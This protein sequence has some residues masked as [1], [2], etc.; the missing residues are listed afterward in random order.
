MFSRKGNTKTTVG[1]EH[2][3][4]GLYISTTTIPLNGGNVVGYLKD[5][6]DTHG[7]LTI[8]GFTGGKMAVTTERTVQGDMLKSRL[9]GIMGTVRSYVKGEAIEMKA[10]AVYVKGEL[11]GVFGE[12][13]LS[14]FKQTRLMQEGYTEDEI[15]IQVININSMES[16]N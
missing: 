4:E 15:R 7:A 6:Y 5:K 9:D 3:V 1:F 2:A 16:I 13:V 10:H 14:R 12:E 11:K 8:E